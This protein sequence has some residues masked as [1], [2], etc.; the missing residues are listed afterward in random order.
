MTLSQQKMCRKT[1][2]TLTRTVARDAA[3]ERMAENMV[4]FKS[5]LGEKEFNL[6]VP[7]MQM[8]R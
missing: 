8:W 3:A 6:Y 5:V 7:L 1:V 4:N 2:K